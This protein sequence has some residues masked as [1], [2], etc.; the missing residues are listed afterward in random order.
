MFDKADLI[1]KNGRLFSADLD[2]RVHWYDAAAVR[3]G[4]IITAGS[5]DEIAGYYSE[6]TEIID[7]G[8]ATVL[9]GLCDSHAHGSYAVEL[10]CGAQAYNIEPEHD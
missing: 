5:D 10:I 8:G 4:K 2:G 3:D 9:P 7:A 1:I 6:N